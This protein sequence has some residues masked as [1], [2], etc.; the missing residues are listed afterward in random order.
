MLSCSVLID[1]GGAHLFSQLCK[2]KLCKEMTESSSWFLAVM[3]LLHRFCVHL[4]G[5]LI[6]VQL[7]A[8][9]L[10]H[11]LALKAGERTNIAS[12]KLFQ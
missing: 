6:G 7:Y 11:L 8:C 5:P 1:E 9:L 10:R 4:Y 3:L 2:A 12:A